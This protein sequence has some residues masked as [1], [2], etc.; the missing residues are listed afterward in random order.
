MAKKCAFRDRKQVLRSN[1]EKKMMTCIVI[2]DEPLAREYLVDQIGKIHDLEILGVFGSP[3]GA[4]EIV[5]TGK[6]DLV[7]SAIQMSELSGTSFLKSLKKPPLFIFVTRDPTFAVESFDLGVVDYVMKPFGLDRLLK[8][9]DKARTLLD[10]QRENMPSRDFLIIKDRN[11]S[12]IMPHGEILFI[13]SDK[14]YVTIATKEKKYTI[15]QRLAKIEDALSSARQFL[16]VHKSYIVNLHFAK[17]INGNEI[18]MKGDV[19]SVPIGVHYKAGLYSRLGIAGDH[20]RTG[21]SC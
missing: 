10:V 17:M 14:D 6:I 19:E 8:A 15:C 3:M 5:K 18:K 1:G 2:D 4:G 20:Q 21:S 7:F 13:K 9:V 12:V 11:Q 16:R